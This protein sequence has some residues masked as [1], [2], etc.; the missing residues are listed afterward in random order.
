MHCASCSNARKNGKTLSIGAGGDAAPARGSNV[1]DLM[2]T[3]KSSLGKSGE[4]AAAPAK[5]PEKK[6]VAAKLPVKPARKRA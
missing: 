2:A 1:I 5:I 4:G 3:L 6:P